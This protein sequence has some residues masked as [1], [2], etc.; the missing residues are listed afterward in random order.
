MQ[1]VLSYIVTIHCCVQ[2]QL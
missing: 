1:K 2:L